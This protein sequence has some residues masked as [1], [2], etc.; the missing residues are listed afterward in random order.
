MPA[1]YTDAELNAMA[2]AEAARISA[3]SLHT[4]SPGTTGANEA[5]GGAPAYARKAVTFNAAGAVG[6]LG[7]TAQ[8]ATVGKAWSS[9]VT[10]DVPA[11][12]YTHFGA[13]SATSGGTYRTG[14]ALAASQGNA[15]AQSQ[16]QVSICVGPVAS[17]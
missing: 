14:N 12:T 1:L 16:V 9:Q 17:A 10:F 5:T 6:P 2:D 13:W 8:P 15:S 7:A 4:A 11:G 3:L